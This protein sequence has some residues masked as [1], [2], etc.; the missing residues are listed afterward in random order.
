MSKLNGATVTLIIA[1]TFILVGAIVFL[2]YTG[3]DVDKY[4]GSISVLVGLLVSA[5]VLGHQQ[6]KVNEKIDKVGH[7]VNGNTTAL[8]DALRKYQERD[9][10]VIAA[11]TAT[12]S[13]PVV[14]VVE[15]VPSEDTITRIE[16][17][18]DDL[19]RHRG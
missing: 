16:A 3:K 14:P 7:S 1:L 18:A 12:G 4:I 10:A 5:G 11:A 6:A 13:Q 8:V 9:A 2:L 15:D 17:E 19:P